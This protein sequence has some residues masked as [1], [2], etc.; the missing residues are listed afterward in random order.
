M[1]PSKKFG[2]GGNS[3][4]KRGELWQCSDKVNFILNAVFQITFKIR[5]SRKNFEGSIALVLS[6]SS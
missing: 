5:E 3:Q 2:E 1:A 6:K 4:K